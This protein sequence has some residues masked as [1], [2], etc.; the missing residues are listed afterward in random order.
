M[1]GFGNVLTIPPLPTPS[2]PPIPYAYPPDPAGLPN[3]SN[4]FPPVVSPPVF[5]DIGPVIFSTDTP[6]LMPAAEPP[7]SFPAYNWE[8]PLD[9][10][11][12][13]FDD[14]LPTFAMQPP[15]TPIST[16]SGI[17]SDYN[18]P[19]LS[20][21]TGSQYVI[22]S[23]PPGYGPLELIGDAAGFVGDVVGGA[24]DV[25]WNAGKFILDNLEV[26]ISYAGDLS[27]QES[28]RKY[29][30]QLGSAQQTSAEAQRTAAE[31]AKIK[32]QAL[33]AQVAAGTMTAE[34]A[35]ARGV[36]L[37]IQTLADIPSSSSSAAPILMTTPVVKTSG[38]NYLLYAAIAAAAYFFLR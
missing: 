7:I 11:G 29:Y 23:S 34:E 20:D 8:A 18:V 2:M 36:G 31:A 28:S 24:A 4:L 12:M 17:L 1:N 25:I 14:P 21:T 10:T 30:E 32:A 6:A 16:G 26:G 9:F 27:K 35:V 38:P 22:P 19:F 33:A 15:A 5:S 3:I 37:G 13:N